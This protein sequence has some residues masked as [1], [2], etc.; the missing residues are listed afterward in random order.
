MRIAFIAT[1]YP[2]EEAPSP[3]LGLTYAAAAC[4]AAGATVRI[5][6]FIVSKYSP[7]KLEAILDTFKP[8]VVGAGSVTMNYYEAERIIKDA[9]RLRPSVITMM[10]GPHVSF[11]IEGTFRSCPELD[12]IIK[13]EGEQTL[14]ELIPVLDDRKAWRGIQGIAFR[15][16]GGIV[17]TEPREL[18]HDLDS[19]PLPARHL[20]PISRYLA[21]GYPVSIITSRGCPNKCIF[22]LGRR[23]VGFKGRFRN[24]KLVVD[25]IEHILS[26]GFI[27]INVA[28]DLFTANKARVRAVCEE[29]GQRGVHFSWTAFA[30]VNTVDLETLRIMREAGCDCVSFGIESGNPEMLKRIRKGITLDQ[31][32]NAVA[33]CKEADILPHA[34]FM[35]GLPGETKETLRQTREFAEE[36]DIA[37]GYHFFAPFPGTT[38]QEE[39]SNYDIEILTHDWRRYDANSPI[40]RTSQLSPEDMTSFVAEYDKINEKIWKEVEQHVREGTCTDRE[41]LQV[42]GNRRLRLVFR[43]LSEDLVEECVEPKQDGTDPLRILSDSVAART[44]TDSTFT[45]TVL[46]GFFDAGYLRHRLV[47]GHYHYYWTHNRAVDVLPIAS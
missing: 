2:L 28:D 24:P 43:I 45:H 35:V 41:Y 6:D 16:D 8:D 14:Q 31:A 44:G 17:I 38:V 46:Q 22:C 12:L 5:F 26:L 47:D 3:P 21:L 30:R 32:R 23:M 15:D 20:L 10:G 18:I 7:E 9:R 37:Y 39:L 25:E 1:P 13:G 34:S 36:L 19:L 29:I 33:W 4:E 40:V 42:E 27:R 11:D